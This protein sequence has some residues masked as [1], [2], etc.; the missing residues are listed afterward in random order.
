[1]VEQTARGVSS[2]AGRGVGG[3]AGETLRKSGSAARG[4]TSAALAAT[5]K[6][7][8][9]GIGERVHQGADRVAGAVEGAGGGDQLTVREELREIVRETALDVLV[10]VAR[11]ATTQAAKYAITRGPQL[12]RDTIAPKLADTVGAAIEEAGG[13]EQFA[14][15][16][17]AS[18]SGARAGMLQR[19]GIGGETR[20][21][22]WRERRLPMEESVDIVVPLATAYDRFGEFDEYARVM[23]RGEAV[24]ARPNERITWERTDGVQAS[25]VITFHRLSDRLTRVMVTYDQDPQGLLEKTT[26]VFRA[27]R[28]GLAADLMRFKAFVEMSEDDADTRDADAGQQAA[29]PRGRQRASARRAEGGSAEPE[30][31]E[32]SRPAPRQPA[33]RRSAARPRQ[34]KARRG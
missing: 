2:A 16:W 22:P 25:A 29:Q 4:A 12:A 15:S 7:A 5:G 21:R 8:A 34:P 1:M 24:D 20:A 10:P 18:A 31:S 14:R 11:T 28:R 9:E 3:V 32:E 6:D 33:R 30:V 13:L 27:S 26:S 23:S 19:V 17:L